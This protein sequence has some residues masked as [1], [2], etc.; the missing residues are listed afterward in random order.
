MPHGPMHSISNQ[1]NTDSREYIL[2]GKEQAQQPP[3]LELHGRSATPNSW[4]EK[5]K[6]VSLQS[7]SMN[8][9]TNSGKKKKK[10]LAASFHGRSVTPNS[11]KKKENEPS[12]KRRK[13]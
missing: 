11:G 3:S 8:S 12:K 7:P 13:I 4:K 9:Q 6:K 5:K 10:S 1:Y 2:E